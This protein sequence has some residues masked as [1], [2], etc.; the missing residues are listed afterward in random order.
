[1]YEFQSSLRNC[2]DPAS[3]Q[4]AARYRADWANLPNIS[5]QRYSTP[6]TACIDDVTLLP[7]TILPQLDHKL[8]EY[9]E[10]VVRLRSSWPPRPYLVLFCPFHRQSTEHLPLP[11][12][13]ISTYIR[14]K[15]FK[16]WLP[17]FILKGTVMVS[18]EIL[19]LWH[20]SL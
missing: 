3:S 1:M 7:P 2:R 18:A 8:S 12:S 11:Q 13:R 4:R 5:S 16:T 10:G 14:H 19:F 15:S 6:A 17:S 20:H 9:A